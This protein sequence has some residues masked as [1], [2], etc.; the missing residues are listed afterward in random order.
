M[1]VTRMPPAGM[2]E[3]FAMSIHRLDRLKGTLNGFIEAA[4]RIGD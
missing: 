2:L 1:A 4:D 3:E